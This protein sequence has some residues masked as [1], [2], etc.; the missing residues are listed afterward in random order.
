MSAPVQRPALIVADGWRDYQL[1]DCGDGMK[2]E[3]W[4][5]FTLVRPDPQVIWPRQG[6]ADGIAAKP[7]PERWE[8]WDGFYH[9]SE[10]GGGSW[11]FRRPLPEHWKIRYHPLGLTFKIRPTSFKHTGLFPEQAVNWE[12]FSALIKSACTGSGEPG[13]TAGRGVRGEQGRTITVLNL[14]GY[15]GAAT[16]AAAKAGAGVCHVDAAEGMVKW[17]RENAA[18]SGLA[19]APVRYIVDDCLKFVRREHKRGRRYDAII[20]DP[21][22]YGRGATGEMWKLEDHLWEL[23]VACRDLLSERPLFFLINA[24]TARLSP[25]VVA[26]LLSELMHGRGGSQAGGAAGSEGAITAGEVG[27]PIQRDGKVLPC[28]IYG[29][30][31]AAP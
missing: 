29:R 28:G 1:I 16:V 12:W 10:Q 27:L 19:N 23:L 15:T 22:T 24:Y 13:G 9:R 5:E 6:A 17:S 30:W 26:N 3:R 21:P 4:G 25:T 11:E 7:V 31:E 18:L 2:Q 8:K 20:M 14:F